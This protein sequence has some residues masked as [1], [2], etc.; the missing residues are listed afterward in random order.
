MAVEDDLIRLSQM[1]SIYFGFGVG[2]DPTSSVI[3]WYKGRLQ[4]ANDGSW[5]FRSISADGT[6]C[7]FQLGAVT[8]NWQSSETPVTG[9]VVTIQIVS[10]QQLAGQ[11]PVVTPFAGAVLQQQLPQELT[12]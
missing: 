8:T 5:I 6:V 7:G 2:V 10:T 9:V 1:D 11:P 3:G 12:G 4:Q